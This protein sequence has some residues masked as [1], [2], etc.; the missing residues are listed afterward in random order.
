[1]TLLLA[2]VAER[3]G[4]SNTVVLD[5]VFRDEDGEVESCVSVSAVV[6]PR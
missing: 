2:A 1:M 6:V 4:S 3:L 5:V